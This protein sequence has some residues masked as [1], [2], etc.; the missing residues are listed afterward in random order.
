[1]PSS[2]RRTECSLCR[3]G[4]LDTCAKLPPTPLANE[5][6]DQPRE[7][8]LFPLELVMCR[9]CQHVQ[10]SIIIDP[11]RLFSEYL[12]ETST[13][14]Q[15]IAHL[16]AE[17][18][19]VAAMLAEQKKHIPGHTPILMEIGSNDGAFLKEF[20]KIC[21]LDG[22]SDDIL[23]IE[24]SSTMCE[25]AMKDKVP[26]LR[27]FFGP[28]IEKLVF[29]R[30]WQAIAANNVL[31]HVPSVRDV[32]ERAA[33]YLAPTGFLV[34]EVGNAADVVNGAFDVVYHEHTSYHALAPLRRALEDVG[35]P[36]F[37][38][39]DIGGEVGRGSLRVW[40]GKFRSPTNRMLDALLKEEDLA[41]DDPQTWQRK[42]GKGKHSVVAA[43]STR[44]RRYFE[45]WK[46][47]ADSPVIGGYG[48][49]A[50]LT[51]L[52][53]ACGLPDV[54]AIAEDSPWK[55]GKLTPGRNIPIVSRHTMLKE[56]APDA[57][58][59]YAWNFADAIGRKLR[60]EGYEG[61][62]YVPMPE[63]RLIP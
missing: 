42:L 44:I 15:T 55:I 49:P 58:I 6:I 12:Y 57:M 56:I 10:T 19:A 60:E 24:P 5:F 45:N 16:K 50:K 41:L 53:Y 22:Y 26:T 20:I 1:M 43:A 8:E 32:L 38:V 2:S 7:Q 28:G 13:S 59:V 9:S 3:S 18:G 54:K 39:E 48:A 63:G 51:T 11:E 30:N 31:A 61:E 40:A 47:R 14:P 62:I 23:G 29:A 33:H 37:D 36:M 4:Q 25:K 21:P 35:M 17:A 52:T 46:L 34:M 27:A